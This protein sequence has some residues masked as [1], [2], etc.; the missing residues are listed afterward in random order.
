MGVYI[1][2]PRQTESST[3]RGAATSTT[4]ASPRPSALTTEA[5]S[6]PLRARQTRHL[7]RRPRE[8]GAAGETQVCPVR[9]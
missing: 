8:G 9:I 4:Q 3:A 1:D 2:T 5:A 6:A 7:A